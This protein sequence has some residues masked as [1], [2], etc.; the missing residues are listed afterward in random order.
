MNLDRI[1]ALL[2]FLDTEVSSAVTELGKVAEGSRKHLQKLVYTNVVDRF[3]ATIDHLLIDNVTV[4]PLLSDSLTAL[5]DP[6]TEGETL[7]LLSPTTDVAGRIR[8]RCEGVLRSSV[9]RERHSRKVKKVFEVLAPTQSLNKPRV[10]INTGAILAQFKCHNKKIPTSIP[11]YAD[12]LYS[13]RNA[14]VHGGG[15]VAML[16]NDLKQ[17]KDCYHCDVAATVKLKIGSITNAV[18][19]FRAV[20][21]LLKGTPS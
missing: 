19:F 1:D 7:R 6:I 12:W 21:K 2:A 4:E 13:R 9:L 16:Q 15:R 5:K 20:A 3:D 10:N 8:E 17:L 11:G 14:I 18:E